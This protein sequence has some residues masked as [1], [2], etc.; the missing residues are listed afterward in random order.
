M[1]LNMED[2][3]MVNGGTVVREQGECV[4]A[5]LREN[6]SIKMFRSVRN[7]FPLPVAFIIVFSTD[8]HSVAKNTMVI[9]LT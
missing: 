5:K 7:G 2:L 3:E 8:A 1:N 4:M 9:G 6:M